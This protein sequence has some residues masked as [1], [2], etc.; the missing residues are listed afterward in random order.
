MIFLCSMIFLLL[1]FPLT[2]PLSIRRA[3]PYKRLERHYKE[4]LSRMD[5]ALKQQKENEDGAPKSRSALSTLST[6]RR[7]RG[8]LSQRGA[9][10]QQQEQQGGEKAGGVGWF[11]IYEEGEDENGEKKGGVSNEQFKG[12]KELAYLWGDL[13]SEREK[14]KENNLVPSTWSG[15][16]VPFPDFLLSFSFQSTFLNILSPLF[17]FSYPK[18]RPSFPQ[19]QL[20]NSRSLMKAKLNRLF[21]P[22]L[23]PPP[24]F[25]TFLPKKTTH[26]EVQS[27]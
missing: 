27:P 26:E 19:N 5:K 13:A 3:I 18:T 17:F 22:Y 9:Q 16:K 23:S 25:L 21:F 14:D 12:A 20:T 24:I 11:Q 2:I 1:L 10:Q 4:F 8:G 15:L 7:G 6:S